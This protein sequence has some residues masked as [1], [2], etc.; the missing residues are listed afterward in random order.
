[1]VRIAT[2]SVAIG[3][4]VMIVSLAVIFG[5]KKEI[6]DKL[7]GFGA[8]VQIVAVDD[9]GSFETLPVERNIASLA[10]ISELGDFAGAYPYALKGGIV[11]GSDAFQVVAFKGVGPDHDWSF[12]EKNLKEGSLLKLDSVRNK[13]VLIS[14][15]LADALELE[16]GQTLDMMMPRRDRFRIKGIYDSGL[17]DMDRTMVVA[18]I[19]DVQRLNGWSPDQVSGIEVM[20]SDFSRLDGFT[21]R[22]SDIIDR[23][24]ES[25]DIKAVNIKERN[26]MIFDWLKVHNVN[27]AVIITVMLLVALFNMIAALLIILLER[28]S[29]IGVLKALG[30]TNGSLQ[31]M[32]VIRSS[33]VIIKGMLWGNIAGVG[34][35]LL[36]HFTGFVTLQSGGYLLTVVPIYLNW[37]WWIALNVIT[38]LFIV[39]LLALPTRIISLILPE[40]SIRFE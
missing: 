10:E 24:G 33:F 31:K 19:R 40:K 21:T 5:F 32:F 35:C 4:A 11:R 12:F 3:M 34:L 14:R 13:E 20:T 37:M 38:F 7:S 39:A 6:S 9:N 27:A 22:I 25:E 8:H 2:L 23:N 16:V 17:E 26:P 1:M 29:M 15:S 36:Q 28:T 30:M 18:D